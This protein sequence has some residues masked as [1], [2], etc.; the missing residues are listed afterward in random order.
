VDTAEQRDPKDLYKQARNGKINKFT[1][2]S[3][4]FQEPLNPEIIV[5]TEQ[6]SV[7]D[8]VAHILEQLSERNLLDE[9]LDDSYTVPI[10]QT[11]EQ[12]ITER[13]HNLG[14]LHD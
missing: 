5:D 11:E 6:Q 1:G 4:P 14:H 12:E 3:H 13:L 10:T 8:S 7:D 2:V 9:I